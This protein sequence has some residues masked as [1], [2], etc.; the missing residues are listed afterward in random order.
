MKDQ[1]PSSGAVLGARA[2][3]PIQAVKRL[4]QANE[5]SVVVA[6]LVLI[7]LIGILKPQFLQGSQL[8]DVIKINFREE[9]HACT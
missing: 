2:L 5:A 1:V 9:Q 8:V 4:F 6:T 7:L 3:N